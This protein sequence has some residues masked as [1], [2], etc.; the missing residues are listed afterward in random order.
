MTSTTAAAPR[1]MLPPGPRGAPILGMLPSAWR[2]PLDLFAGAARDHGD[3]VHFRFGPLHYVLLNDPEAARHVLVTRHAAY[4]KSRSYDG[5][6]VILGDG[7]LTSEGAVWKRQRHLAQPAFQPRSLQRIVDPIVTCTRDVVDAWAAAGDGARVDAHDEMMRL[8]LRIVGL[9]LMGT[10]LER[11]ARAV[12]EALTCA[13]EWAND[14]AEAIVRVPPWV[15]TP[16][17]FRF[18]RAMQT[19]EEVVQR[20]VDERRARGETGDDLLGL[21]MQ[22]RAEGGGAMSDRQL[23][24]ELMTM[25]L[26][27]H[28]TTAVALSWTWHLLGRHPE[29]AARMRDEAREVLG[30]RD[31]TWDDLPRLEQTEHVLR[32][33]MRL[34]PPAW[35]VERR[36]IE[37]DVIGG[38]RIPKNATVAV[39]P[40]V[41][42]RHPGAWERPD[43]FDPTRFTHE[44]SAHRARYAYLPFGAGPRVCI[45]GQLAMIEAKLI[46]AMIAR[47]FRLEPASDAAIVPEPLVTLRPRGGVPVVLRPA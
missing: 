23:R 16:T 40:F 35:I 9:A 27:G 11:D 18:R 26:A 20:I 7:L 28:E 22:A 8:T 37:D 10:D 30:D 36:A 25:V 29:W 17:N 5:L 34:Y 24:D 39:S 1:P 15:P 31:P 13:I 12:G 14:W 2:D 21:F 41:L 19:L 33:A 4:V 6:R 44:R 32:E 47:R 45:G 46:A 42:H 43:D 3:F 38:Y